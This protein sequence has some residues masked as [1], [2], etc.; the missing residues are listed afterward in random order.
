M[1]NHSSGSRNFWH[2]RRV[3]SPL[4]AGPQAHSPD[5][6]LR[7]CANELAALD[8]VLAYLAE[9]PRMNGM[10]CGAAEWCAFKDGQ[11]FSLGWDWF[12]VD[13]RGACIDVHAGIRTNIQIRDRQGYDLPMPASQRHLVGAICRLPWQPVP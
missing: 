1:T 7:L 12:Q 5:G 13:K 3:P 8:W 6:Y 4:P 11:V 2:H 10:R 9:D